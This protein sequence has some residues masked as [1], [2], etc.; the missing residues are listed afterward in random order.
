MGADAPGS[1]LIQ[2]HQPVCRDH[3]G[4]PVRDQQ[5]GA[6]PIRIVQQIYNTVGQRINYVARIKDNH[7]LIMNNVMSR[8]GKLH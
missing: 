5:D 3:G 2:Q 1:A 8:T 4:Q 6:F 7:S